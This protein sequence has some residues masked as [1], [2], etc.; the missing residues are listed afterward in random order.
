LLINFACILQSKNLPPKKNLKLS[1]A[2]RSR[3]LLGWFLAT[4]GGEIRPNYFKNS[5][6][7]VIYLKREITYF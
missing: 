5:P 6:L 7:L 3:D 2:R 1:A 4:A